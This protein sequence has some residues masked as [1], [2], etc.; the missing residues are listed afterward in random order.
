MRACVLTLF[1]ALFF[2]ALPAQAACDPSSGNL[3]EH[4]CSLVGKTMMS[5]DG[6]SIIA[7]V[8]DTF[9]RCE[10]TNPG[11]LIWKTYSTSILSIDSGSCPEN[12]AIDSIVNGVP[13]CA[14]Y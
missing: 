14:P 11:D 5:D 9:D 2:A 1:C 12:Q 8:C 13:H 10:K 6:H 3:P 7:C 4:C